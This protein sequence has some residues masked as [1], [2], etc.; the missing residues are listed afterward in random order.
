MK[1]SGLHCPGCGHRGGNAGAGASAVIVL[2]VLAVVA[3][4]RR[5][6]GHAASVAVHVLVIAAEVGTGLAAAAGATAAVLV[7][8]RRAA[9]L[10]AVSAAREPAEIPAPVRVL[11]PPRRTPAE[12]PAPEPSGASPLAVHHAGLDASPV[13]VPAPA[14][15]ANPAD[16]AH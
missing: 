15:A 6:I 10:S 11:G 12:L 1:C 16:Q 3:A 9:C 14:W 7:I 8:R 4:N 13:I 2:I 5:A